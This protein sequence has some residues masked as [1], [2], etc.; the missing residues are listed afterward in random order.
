MEMAKTEKD[1]ER[2]KNMNGKK[3]RVF[4][5][6]FHWFNAKKKKIGLAWFIVV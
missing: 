3:N 6:P 4:N 5:I 1:G 2:T